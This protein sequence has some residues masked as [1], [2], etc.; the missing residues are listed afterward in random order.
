MQF[1]ER[2]NLVY[3]SGE[4][5]VLKRNWGGSV[6]QSAP[7]WEVERDDS[8]R[9]KCDYRW[10]IEPIRG[11]DGEYLLRNDHHPRHAVRAGIPLTVERRDRGQ[12]NHRWRV[13]FPDPAFASVDSPFHICSVAS[14][15][16]LTVT[17]GTVTMERDAPAELWQARD[18]TG[19]VRKAFMKMVAKVPAPLTPGGQHQI[20]LPGEPEPERCSDGG[21]TSFAT[22]SSDDEAS[23]SDRP[24]LQHFPGC[25][26]QAFERLPDWGADFPEFTSYQNLLN[27]KVELCE[28]W[29]LPCPAG[30]SLS[31]EDV[32]RELFAGGS[33]FMGR[34]Q[35]HRN[36]TD[37]DWQ[38]PEPRENEPW[39][40][41]ARLRGLATVPVVGRRPYEE[42]QRYLLCRERTQSVLALQQVGFLDVGW[43]VGKVRNEVLYLFAQE[44][45]NGPVHLRALAPVPPNTSFK[46]TMLKGTAE[47]LEDF[48]VVVRDLL[49]RWQ[50][51]AVRQATREDSPDS[52]VTAPNSEI[53]DETLLC[54]V[55][56][57]AI[58]PSL[59]LGAVSACCGSGLVMLVLPRSG[60]GSRDP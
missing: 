7:H 48:Q 57:A 2:V 19:A 20:R 13:A 5:W 33:S 16:Y 22:A 56:R 52:F 25:L 51:P 60:S 59:R 1:P 10:L 46:Q 30:C 9:Y 41:A 49:E 53:S 55:K 36:C 24:C 35:Q 43:P 14:G 34:Y 8:H 40:A 27:D 11:K 6:V 17:Q 54:K 21:A 29:E 32:F 12:I 3:G 42:F 39:C 31:I 28:A 15:M 37:L 58:G 38:P 26:A 50:P 45:G 4:R 44:S 47:A 23:P 18:A